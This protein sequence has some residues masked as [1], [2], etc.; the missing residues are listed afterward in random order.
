M[1][2]LKLLLPMLALTVAACS[3]APVDGA[4]EQCVQGDA[5]D[6]GTV[7]IP[8][9]LP[10]SLGFGGDLCTNSCNV[11]NDCLQDLSDSVLCVNQQCY[12]QCPINGA[13]CPNGTACLSFQDEEGFE[14]DLCTP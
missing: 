12:F 11:A 6:Q 13:S 5:C 7:C 1:S 2:R 3:S 8:T 9:S 14:V 10:P 4:Y